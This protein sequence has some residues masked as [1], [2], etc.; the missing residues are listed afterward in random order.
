M[1]IA[2]QFPTKSVGQIASF[3][4]NIVI[5]LTSRPPKR[6]VEIVFTQ[7]DRIWAKSVK[8]GDAKLPGF[9]FLQVGHAGGVAGK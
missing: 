3:V 8:A 7:D 1:L 4:G 2:W 9:A 5:L 6:W